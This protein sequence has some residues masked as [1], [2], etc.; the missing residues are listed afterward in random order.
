MIVDKSNESTQDLKVKTHITRQ[1]T[2][3]FKTQNMYADWHKAYV[4]LKRDNPSK[5]N[6]WISKQIAKMDIAKACKSET[7]RKNM[8]L[9]K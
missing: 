9:K 1:D 6:V 7:I 5:S 4:K 3:K 2:R 8:V